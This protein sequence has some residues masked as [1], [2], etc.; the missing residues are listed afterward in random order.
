MFCKWCGKK[1]TNNGIP[2]PS[3]G[4]DQ[5]ALEN[6]NGFWDLCNIKPEDT[7]SV[8]VT[9]FVPAQKKSGVN[10]NPSKQ[11]GPQKTGNHKH[12][13]ARFSLLHIA[14]VC[15]LLITLIAVFVGIGKTGDCLSELNSIRADISSLSEL[16]NGGFE[17]I[18][19]YHA[20]VLNPTDD[21]SSKDSEDLVS[22]AELSIDELLE[23]NA[24][25]LFL[26]HNLN[27]ES[28]ELE[29]EPAYIVHIASGDLLIEENIKIYWQKTTDAGDTWQTIS[30]GT[31]YLVTEQSENTVYRIL[32]LMDSDG[33]SKRICYY[34]LTAEPVVESDSGDDVTD[35][36]TS[37]DPTEETSSDAGYEQPEENSDLTTTNE[38]GENAVG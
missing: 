18:E 36:T 37:E 4:R 9:D 13:K 16:V 11:K 14:T 32:C 17:E 20:M 2:C 3:C 23:S 12:S 38:D 35:P 30:E 29:S 24:V 19:E 1:I 21:P 33:S 26:T 28:H 10:A 6:G 27:V 15:L 7:G 5:D 34:A 22:D 8:P 31:S 25:I